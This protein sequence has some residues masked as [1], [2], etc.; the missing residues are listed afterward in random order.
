MKP[1]VKYKY[2]SLEDFLISNE[3]NVDG[4]LDDG[5]GAFF[6]VKGR[7]INA[8]ILFSDISSFSSRTIDLTSTEVLIFVNNF[9]SWITAEALRNKKGIIDKYIGDEMMIVFSKE[10]GS[11]DP[12]VDALQ[13]ARWMCQND[14]LNF[15]PHIGIA[16]GLVTV[17]YVGTPLKYNCSVFGYPV[18][19]AS[20]CASI[21]ID[22]TEELYSS[23]IIFPAN[24]WQNQNL[25]DIFPNQSYETPDGG[26]YEKKHNFE[27]LSPKKVEL[28]NIGDIE[29]C[30][31]V[32]RAFWKPTITPQ[33]R[34]QV[35][36]NELHKVGLYRPISKN[37]MLE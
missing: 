23:S 29:I 2:N 9:F 20:R 11:E 15:C 1:A 25:D 35:A 12:F 28:K 27:L 8:T 17:G 5:W 13:A 18:T 7:E 16:S 14:V 3:L 30:A 24:L 10:F 4:Q 26:T 37:V 22:K 6:P 21:K 19:L 34:A 32:N 36:A 31:I 33:E